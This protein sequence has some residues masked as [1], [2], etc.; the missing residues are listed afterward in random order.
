MYQQLGE[1]LRTGA[2]LRS[3]GH[4]MVH[5]GDYQQAGQLYKESLA[6]FQELRYRWGITLGL[7]ALGG[8]A[9]LSGQPERTATLLGAVDTHRRAMHQVMAPADLAEFETN[10]SATRLALSEES[11]LSA[12]SEGET[13]TV[14][15]A[16]GYALREPI[17]AYRTI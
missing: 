6:L 4:V 5:R 9:R 13:M 12:W 16:L 8:L 17:M 3:L 1:R 7:A 15:Q 11:F 14:E 2:L 10:L